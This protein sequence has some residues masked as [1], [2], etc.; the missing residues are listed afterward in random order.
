MEIFEHK[1]YKLVCDTYSTSRAWGHTAVLFEHNNEIHKA[2]VRYINRTWESFRYQSV[3][4]N[5]IYDMIA[6]RK[7][8]I[9]YDYKMKTGAT[10]LTKRTKEELVG[11]D[12]EIMK[13]E[14]LYEWVRRGA[15]N[16]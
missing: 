16:D 7:D 2:K 12:S 3:M 9:I 8:R 10:R 6:S 15:K 13:L 5:C 11:C 14:D 1:D 4:L